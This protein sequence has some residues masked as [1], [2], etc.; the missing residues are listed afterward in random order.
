MTGILFLLLSFHAPLSL[1]KNEPEY[2]ICSYELDLSFVLKGPVLS[3]YPGDGD[4]TLNGIEH[5]GKARCK[6]E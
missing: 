6:D 1:Q 2:R 3:D 4:R 5:H